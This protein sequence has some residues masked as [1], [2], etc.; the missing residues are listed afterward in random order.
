MAKNVPTNLFGII[1]FGCSPDPNI[2]MAIHKVDKDAQPR[3][4]HDPKILIIN[5]KPKIS[6]F[7]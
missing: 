5:L 2:K 4:F 7:G 3:S 1:F 6:R